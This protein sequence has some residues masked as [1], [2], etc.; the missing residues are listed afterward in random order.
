MSGSEL[1]KQLLDLSAELGEILKRKGLVMCTAES[2]T[3]GLIS[4]YVTEI[5]GSSAWFDRAFITYTNEAKH[6]MLGVSEKTLTEF[7]AVSG[8]VVMQMVSGA[9]CRSNAGVGVA[10]SGIAGPTGGTPDKPV[11]TVWM[12]WHFPDGT[13]KTEKCLFS[14]SR[15]EVRLKTVRHA[16]QVLISELG[17]AFD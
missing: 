12:A 14:G 10:V 5:S 11:G 13:V 6:E 15:E 16:F 8:E 2:C 17:S 1:R 4:G 7:G 3:G 9:V